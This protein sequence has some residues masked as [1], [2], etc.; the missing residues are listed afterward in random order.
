MA[1]PVIDAVRLL[2]SQSQTVIKEFKGKQIP[3]VNRNSIVV[4]TDTSDASAIVVKLLVRSS[5]SVY[6]FTGVLV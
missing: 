1:D 2:Q 4:W 6:S 3:D 5:G